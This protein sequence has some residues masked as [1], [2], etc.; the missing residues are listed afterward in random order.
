M[1]NIRSREAE[2]KGETNLA[3]VVVSRTTNLR[4]SCKCETA[5]ELLRIIRTVAKLEE[6]NLHNIII[7]RTGFAIS[8]SCRP[9]HKLSC[10]DQCICTRDRVRVL[11][12]RR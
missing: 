8:C 11:D 7:Q 12:E 9:K 5:E 3:S 6:F 1:A 4:Q 10:A 2:E